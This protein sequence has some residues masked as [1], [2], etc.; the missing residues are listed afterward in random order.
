MT[1][2]AVNAVKGPIAGLG[3]ELSILSGLNGNKP[4]AAKPAL[5]FLAVNA[6]TRAGLKREVKCSLPIVLT[7]P[8]SSRLTCSR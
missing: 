6:F 3:I 1:L 7:P 4:L 2:S 8:R 5:M